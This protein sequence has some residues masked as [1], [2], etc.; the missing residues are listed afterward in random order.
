MS[1]GD[2][3]FGLSVS[4]EPAGRSR[5]VLNPGAA[6]LDWFFP[7]PD[8]TLAAVGLSEGRSEQSVLRLVE[9]DS[10]RLLPERLRFASFARVAWLPDSGAFYYSTGIASDTENPQT[11]P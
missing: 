9:T 4:D 8:G 10:G 11:A 6:S 7:S 5:L 3:G 1:A 2:A